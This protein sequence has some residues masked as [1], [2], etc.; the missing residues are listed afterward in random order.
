MWMDGWNTK[1]SHFLFNQSVILRGGDI[2]KA[3]ILPPPQDHKSLIISAYVHAPI[4]PQTEP[5]ISM[6]IFQIIIIR[7]VSF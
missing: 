1:T 7:V 3:F 5:K 6:R 2:L 4:I